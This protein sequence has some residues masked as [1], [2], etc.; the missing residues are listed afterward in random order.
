MEHPL[1][2]PATKHLATLQHPLPRGGA[3]TLQQRASEADNT[4]GTTLWTGAQVLSA[5]LS[6]TVSSSTEKQTTVLELGAGIGFLALALAEA[7]LDV[8]TTDIEPVLSVLSRNV[9]N[10][11]A[12]LPAGSGSVRVAELDWLAEDRPAAIA[13]LDLPHI[14]MVVT[15]DTVYAPHLSP[16]LWATLAAVCRPDPAAGHAGV[17][18]YIALERRDPGLVDSSLEIGRQA[19]CDLRRVAHGRVAKIVERTWGWKPEDWEG[20]EVWKGRFK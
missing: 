20:V 14:D 5:Y 6:K 18:L 17:P 15:A 4:T 1:P 9:G 7:G 10:C 11:A 16:A 3:V 12:S 13:A 8:V 2:A 19:G